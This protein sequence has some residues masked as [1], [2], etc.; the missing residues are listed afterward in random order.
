MANVSF[1]GNHN[2]GINSSGSIKSSRFGGPS[3]GQ[4]I[5]QRS[6]PSISQKIANLIS[7]LDD[8]L[9]EDGLDESLNLLGD[10]ALNRCLDLRT[11]LRKHQPKPD[12]SAI[13]TPPSSSQTAQ[14]TQS[15][16]IPNLPNSMSA[17][18]LTP[19]TGSTIP[20][21]LPPLPKVLDRTLE[22]AAFVHVS[23]GSGRLTD[24]NYE[25]LEWVGDAYLYLTSTLLIS[26]TFPSLLPGKCSQLRERLVKNM[27]LADYARQYGFE[28]RAVFSEIASVRASVW[29]SAKE[30]DKSK[31]MGDMFEAYVAAV[32]LSDPI[33]GVAR[34]SEWLKGLWAMTLRKEILTEERSGVKID[35]PLWRL[36][37]AA[38]P[39]EIISSEPK[40]LNAKDTLSRTIGAKGIKITYREAAP[41]KKDKNSKLPVFTVGVYLDGWGEKDKQLGFGAALGKKEAGMK[42]AEMALGNKKLMKI[43]VEKKRLYDAQMEMEMK[44]LEKQTALVDT[45]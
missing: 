12:L 4:I 41:E 25:R 40:S 38:A 33:D 24:L 30:Y 7:A 16:D 32:V 6:N 31:I 23:S 14:E 2:N 43:Y 28:K 15:D 13:N 5:E 35:S 29:D 9:E 36:R 17:F 39:I 34:V 1:Q 10:E 22:A 26:Q 21:V 18:S 37:G 11:I 20:T 8:A 27:T 44:V 19:W 45:S 42:A 3:S